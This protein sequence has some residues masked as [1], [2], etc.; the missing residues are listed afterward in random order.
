VTQLRRTVPARDRLYL[1]YLR[2]DALPYPTYETLPRLGYG[3]TIPTNYDV[4]MNKATTIFKLFNAVFLVP[5]GATEKHGNI[6]NAIFNF[7]YDNVGA[8]ISRPRA[9]M[10]VLQKMLG[11]FASLHGFAQQIM[12]IPDYAARAAGCRP[13][14]LS[15]KCRQLEGQKWELAKKFPFLRRLNVKRGLPSP[16]HNHPMQI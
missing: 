6:V 11:K 13:L 16:L 12:N 4:G 5:D 9:K 10:F 15:T 1:Q 3:C 7:V 14:K 2:T 8:A